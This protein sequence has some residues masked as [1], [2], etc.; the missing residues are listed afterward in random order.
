MKVSSLYIS[1][2]TDETKMLSR[3]VGRQSSSDAALYQE[4]MVTAV[5]KTNVTYLFNCSY[6]SIIMQH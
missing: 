4:R 2:L 5:M 3:N 1:T 6:T